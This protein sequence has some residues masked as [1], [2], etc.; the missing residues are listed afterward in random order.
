MSQHGLYEDSPDKY[1]NLL[2]CFCTHIDNF[3]TKNAHVMFW[4]AMSQ[5][6]YYERTKQELSRVLT[7]NPLPL[8]WMKSD[9]VGVAPDPR[10]GP[11]QIYEAAFL[12]WRGDR[13][14]VKV[15]ANAYSAPS[16]KSIHPS[17]KP[18]PVLKH[19]FE[20]LVDG[21]TKLLD[22][23]CGGGSSLR[24]AEF[25]NAEY[26]WGMDIDPEHVKNA[27]DENRKFRIKR[28]MSQ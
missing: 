12:A 5:E 16:D 9:N 1:W 3:L 7:V 18:E 2:D 25:W 4:F 14:I 21:S 27:N 11:R 24:A 6:G 10:R 17:A 13:P 23:T 22:P 15:K 19:F 8:I 20:M 28:R 26:V